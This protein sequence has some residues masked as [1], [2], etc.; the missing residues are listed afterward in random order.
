[1]MSYKLKHCIRRPLNFPV[2]TNALNR[3][4]KI[5]NMLIDRRLDLKS[6]TLYNDPSSIVIFL[7][8]LSF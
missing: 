2:H 1:M 8:L 4:S 6:N 7:M 5:D 3:R